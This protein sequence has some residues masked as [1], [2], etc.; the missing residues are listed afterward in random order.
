MR[1]RSCIRNVNKHFWCHCQGGSQHLL[2]VYRLHGV[3]LTSI[4]SL[5][6]LSA[7]MCLFMVFTG[8][9]MTGFDLPANY[10]SDLE[11]LI[12]KSRL[13]LS[14]PGSSGSHVRE[15]VDKFQGSPPP[16]KPA[17]MAARRCIN[18]FSAPS[19]ANVRNSLEKNIGDGSFDIKPALINM[20]QQ[21]PFCSKT[22]EDVNA[23]LQHFL[24][25]CITFTIRGITQDVVRLH[26]FPFSL[27]GKEK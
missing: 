19:S 5:T 25:I 4:I 12:R 7:A 9:C 3:I 23:H 10:L 6:D 11:S 1:L 8:S 22:S 18:D 21:S 20:V 16:H 17:L 24:E 27:L 13:R 2:S 14:S 26:L 15:I